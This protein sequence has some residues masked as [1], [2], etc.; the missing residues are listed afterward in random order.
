MVALGA[1]STAVTQLHILRD[2]VALFGAALVVV[3]VLRRLR[4]PTI[5]GFLIIGEVMKR[6]GP[7]GP[8]PAVSSLATRLPSGLEVESLPVHEQA[9]IA[10]RTL[11]EA[12]L[13]ARTGAT[14]VAVSRGEATAVHP[15]PEDVLEVGDV[16]C[17][18]GSAL[19][20]SAARE[21][22]EAGPKD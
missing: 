9:W 20:I 5:A 18:V 7:E 13:R 4:L 6:M 15:A 17:L 21:L 10:G 8:E 1:L 11:A 16:V 14:L 22:L 3:L 12:R 2:L 19:Q